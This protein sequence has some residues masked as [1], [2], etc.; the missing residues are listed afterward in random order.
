MA[1]IKAFRGYRYNAEKIANLGSV[2]SPPYYNISEEDK[3]GLYEKSDYNS[4]RLFSG[5][6]YDDDTPE[7]SAFTRAKAYLD[8][9]IEEE[10]LIRD[11]EPVIL[12]LIHI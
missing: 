5:K 7:N 9:W 4:V 2:V 6:R 12:S 10:I 11:E 3:D 1:K 8:K